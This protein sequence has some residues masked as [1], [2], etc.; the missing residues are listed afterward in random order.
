MAISGCDATEPYRT[1]HMLVKRWKLGL[2]DNRA[3]HTG[4]FRAA[5]ITY[6]RK[7]QQSHSSVG[8]K[9]T[10]L[11]P[12]GSNRKLQTKGNGANVM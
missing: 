3:D 8:E 9:A 7:R 4:A 2:R 12:H 10:F 6:L 1:C 11:T 5:E